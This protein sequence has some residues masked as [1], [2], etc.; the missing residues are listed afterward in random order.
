M[1][2]YRLK[3][4]QITPTDRAE[5]SPSSSRQELN[6]ISLLSAQIP[7]EGRV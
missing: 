2:L 7:K 6:F 3:G 5:R 1:L 4:G